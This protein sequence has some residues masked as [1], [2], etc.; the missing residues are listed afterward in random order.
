MFTR[1]WKICPHCDGEGCMACQGD[2]GYY[3][4]RLAPS[5]LLTNDADDNKACDVCGYKHPRP[6][7]SGIVIECADGI[8][9]CKVCRGDSKFQRKTKG[10]KEQ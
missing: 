7:T 2:G 4:A 5:P 8:Y 9:R 3:V 10:Q 6:D 1:E